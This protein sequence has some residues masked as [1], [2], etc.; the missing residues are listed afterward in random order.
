MEREMIGRRSAD[1]NKAQELQRQLDKEIDALYGQMGQKFGIGVQKERTALTKIVNDALVSSADGPTVTPILSAEGL[2]EGATFTLG[3]MTVDSLNALRKAK[4]KDPEE[5]IRILQRAR[6][7]MDK[8]FT[9][10]ASNVFR[11][12]KSTKE[13]ADDTLNRFAKFKTAF[14][15]K[16]LDY[17]D[18][19]YRS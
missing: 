10:I 16:S 5:V 7:T 12:G 8:S 11:F 13:A 1:A 9:D 6:R 3:N 15:T 19:T 4:L 18:D 2:T 17:I 14:E